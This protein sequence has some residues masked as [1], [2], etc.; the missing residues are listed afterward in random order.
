MTVSHLF[1]GR[2]AATDPSAL[3]VAFDA[4][5][6]RVAVVNE[7][8]V[9]VAVNRV[10]RDFSQRNGLSSHASDL[11][12]AYHDVC[13]RGSGAGDDDGKAIAQAVRDLLSGGSSEHILEYRSEGLSEERWFV[14]R[15]KGEVMAG[16]RYVSI[17]HQDVTDRRALER[18][19]RVSARRELEALVDARSRELLHANRQL[20]D[21]E[22]ELRELTTR[23]FTAQ[24]DER[25][26]LARE[27]H[28]GF[29]QE[30]AAAS[31]QLGNLRQHPEVVDT[32]RDQLADIQ[33]HIVGLSND[34]RRVSHELHP[35]ALEQL[36]LEAA[37]RAHCASF[38]AHEQLIVDFD[39]QA[40]PTRLPYSVSTCAFRVAQAAL[41]NVVRH[42]GAR[43]ASVRLLVVDGGIELRVVDD[44][45]GFDVSEA[46]KARG[47]GLVSMQE[48][49]RSLGGR[50]EVSSNPGAG[51]GVVAH[52]PVGQSEASEASEADDAS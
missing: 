35:A 10:W 31:I 15:I 41:R 38:A 28:D 44:G 8:G 22:R 24:E 47:L 12:H 26:R 1:Q 33:N 20:R 32:I 34:L 16:R 11:G 30:M 13:E 19:R 6:W 3:Q 52:L 5:P 27:F 4:L 40:F 48:R 42:S 23:L 29:G 49:V 18:V 39:S 7:D 51:T 25:R 37:L 9:I 45:C 43:R 2:E 36:G 46:R 17:V 21:T 50:L 14:V